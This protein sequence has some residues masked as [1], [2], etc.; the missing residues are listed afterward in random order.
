MVKKTTDF[1]QVISAIKDLRTEF[2]GKIDK[3][4]ERIDIITAPPI[5]NKPT[6][7]KEE[8]PTDK[9]TF[10]VPEEYRTAV[11]EILSDRF[12][13]KVIPSTSGPEFLFQLLV[14]Q[15]YSNAGEQ[16]WKDAKAD[17]R[18]KV[19]T[20]GEGLLGVKTYIELVKTNLGPEINARIAQD[21]DETH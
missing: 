4:N 9:T 18:S 1:S 7:V 6:E 21:K 16:I 19:L 13:I 12:G 10:P 2:M 8:A 5:I 15:E 11:N 3:M 14:P 20:H 17:I